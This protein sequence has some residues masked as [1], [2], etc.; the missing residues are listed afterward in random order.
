MAQEFSSYP[1]N[2]IYPSIKEYTLTYR[3]LSI[4]IS[5]I[6]LD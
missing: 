1:E 3:E 4:L 5:G 6:F 2:P